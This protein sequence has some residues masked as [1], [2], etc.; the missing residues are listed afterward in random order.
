MAVIC[1][2]IPQE[3]LLLLLFSAIDDRF[4]S[5]QR[6]GK[7]WIVIFFLT[8]P[9]NKNVYI[10]WFVISKCNVLLWLK[11]TERGVLTRDSQADAQFSKSLCHGPQSQFNDPHSDSTASFFSARESKSNDILSHSTS[12]GIFRQMR[13]LDKFFKQMSWHL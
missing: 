8:W 1:S 5:G 2:L 11:T 13:M 9:P 7:N 3:G 12:D 10:I 4:F 6:A